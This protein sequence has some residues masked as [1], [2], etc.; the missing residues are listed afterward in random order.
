V[1]LELLENIGAFREFHR[2]D[3]ESVRTSTKAQLKDFDYYFDFVVH[4]VSSMK[5]L[6]NK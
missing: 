3:W 5:S 6:W 2:P 4:L 1:P